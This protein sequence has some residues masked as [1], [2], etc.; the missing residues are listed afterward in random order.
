M[1]QLVS[2]KNL[3]ICKSLQHRL[4]EERPSELLLRWDAFWDPGSPNQG[5]KDEY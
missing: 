5:V 4:C 2:Y 1:P 3:H